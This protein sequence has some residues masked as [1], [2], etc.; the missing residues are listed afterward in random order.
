MA[1]GRVVALLLAVVGLLATVEAWRRMPLGTPADPGPGMLP[2]LLAATLAVL[3]AAA[4]LGRRWPAP[5]PT[6]GR[7]AIAVAAL[8]V[9]YPAAL[10]WLGFAVTTALA[11]FLLARALGPVSSVRLA[12]FALVTSAAAVLLFRQL[13]AVPLP[14]G[15]WGF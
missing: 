5:S 3:G 8:L 2:L 12:A 11:L 14:R 4:A 6:A 7:R 9:A 10:P 15:P 1:P 13:L